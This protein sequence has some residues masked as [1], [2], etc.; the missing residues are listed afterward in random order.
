MAQTRLAFRI[1]VRFVIAILAID[2]L[3]FGAAG[4]F[5]WPQAWWLTALF[6]G[7]FL[8]GGPWMLRHDPD[9]LIERMNRSPH[10]VPRW[11]RVVLGLYR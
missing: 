3:L 11:D 2:L 10:N 5:D 8:I 9:L 1:V 4:R 6:A 7:T